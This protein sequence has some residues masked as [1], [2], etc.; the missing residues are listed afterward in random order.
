[1]LTIRQA[2]AYA[3]YGTEIACVAVAI[4]VASAG[5]TSLGTYMLVS[6]CYAH[7]VGASY[8]R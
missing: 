2:L 4:A 3:L 6:A 7:L 5:D 1:M 8:G